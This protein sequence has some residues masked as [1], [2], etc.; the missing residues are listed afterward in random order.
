LVPEAPSTLLSA[1]EREYAEFMR[2]R[3]RLLNRIRRQTP[4]KQT[5][6]EEISEALIDCEKCPEGLVSLTRQGSSSVAPRRRPSC[7]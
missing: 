3:V 6:L 5:L 7:P 1:R 2:I 4:E